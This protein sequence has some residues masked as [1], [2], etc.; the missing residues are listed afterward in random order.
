M[1][2]ACNHI[3]MPK[4]AQPDFAEVERWLASWQDTL[5]VNLEKEDGG[6]VIPQICTLA[7]RIPNTPTCLASPAINTASSVSTPMF[8]NPIPRL[9]SI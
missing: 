4:P 1:D 8:Y 7:S 6:A 9:S 2:I 5:C 3:A